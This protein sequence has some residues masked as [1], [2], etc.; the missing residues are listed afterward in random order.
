[1]T[2]QEIQEKWEQH[3]INRDKQALTGEEAA[4]YWQRSQARW[5]SEIALQLAVMNERKRKQ[6]DDKVS[7]RQTAGRKERTA[8]VR[9]SSFTM[10][11]RPNS[12]NVEVPLDDLKQFSP[13]PDQ[14]ELQDL[15]IGAIS[16]GTLGTKTD[17]EVK[18]TR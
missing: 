2:S 13:N 11:F 8:S 1:M 18:R 4:V 3:V 14:P 6:D 10:Y 15:E 9:K 7:S 12:W 16:I 5:M 17:V